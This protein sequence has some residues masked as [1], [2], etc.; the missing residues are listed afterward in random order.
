MSARRRDERSFRWGWSMDAPIARNYVNWTLPRARRDSFLCCLLC[1]ACMHLLG[2]ERESEVEKRRR[3]RKRPDG[4]D[5]ER[6]GIN[7]RNEEEKR[8]RWVPLGHI[9]VL[10][11]AHGNAN[12]PSIRLSSFEFSGCVRECPRSRVHIIKRVTRFK[13]FRGFETS[14]CVRR[15][16]GFYHVRATYTG[17]SITWQKYLERRTHAR[18]F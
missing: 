17:D 2:G 9:E 7:G 16:V 11:F 15:P 5:K 18:S 4:W 10:P 13:W 8:T 12:S 3:E 1:R 14:D 6:N